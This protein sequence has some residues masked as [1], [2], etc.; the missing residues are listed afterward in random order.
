MIIYDFSKLNLVSTVLSKRKLRW[1]VENGHVE[2]WDDPRFPTVSG[3]LRRGMTVEGLKQFILS[4]GASKN[5][6][7]MTWDKIWAFNRSVIDPVSSRYVA[8]LSAGAVAVALR[9][10]LPIDRK[11]CLFRHVRS[12]SACRKTA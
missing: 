11:S 5:T 2:G 12:P 7:L 8:L 10:S 6:N 9:W 4:M 1:F 3:V